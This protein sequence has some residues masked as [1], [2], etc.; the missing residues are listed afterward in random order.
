MCQWKMDQ[1]EQNRM[2]DLIVDPGTCT[3]SG[4]T[5]AKNTETIWT[6]TRT[7]VVVTILTNQV[8]TIFLKTRTTKK[9]KF[10]VNSLKTLKTAEER[11]NSPKLI[12]SMQLRV[13]MAKK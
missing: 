5:K 1:N 7:R 12:F 3:V 13:K 9:K 6:G 2:R 4:L 8:V 11:V 10:L